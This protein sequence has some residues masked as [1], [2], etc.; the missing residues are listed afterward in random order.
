MDRGT[1]WRLCGAHSGAVESPV[2]WGS[3]QPFSI[4]GSGAVA[5]SFHTD[6]LWGS[7]APCASNAC[8]VPIL[9]DVGL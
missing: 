1:G 3:P 8:V 2:G 9:R 5:A 7:V 4:S 6:S